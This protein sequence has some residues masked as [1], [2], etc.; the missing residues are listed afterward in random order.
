MLIYF[1]GI[2]LSDEPYYH[3]FDQRNRNAQYEEYGRTFELGFTWQM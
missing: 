2:N 1:N 3:Y